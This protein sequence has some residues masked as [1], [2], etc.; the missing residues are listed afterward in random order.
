MFILNLSQIYRVHNAVIIF[1]R[2]AISRLTLELL[3]DYLKI[4]LYSACGVL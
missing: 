1:V 2:E 3:P 4:L